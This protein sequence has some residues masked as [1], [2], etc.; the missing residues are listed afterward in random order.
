MFKHLIKSLIILLLIPGLAMAT[1]ESCT[2]V[3]KSDGPNGG[4]KVTMTCTAD[5]TDGSMDVTLDSTQL[6]DDGVT[7]VQDFMDPLWIYT[8]TA[9]P[10]GTAP[11][12]ASDFSM[13]DANGK[14]CVSAT[15]NGLNVIDAT[16]TVEFYTEGPGGVSHY[17]RVDK[18]NDL[19]FSI[20]NNIVNSAII[21]FEW[22]L[23]R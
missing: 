13:V 6:C 18:D 7:Q 3:C 12:D 23:E 21:I 8:I 15:A 22:R 4:R 16:S 19:T 17:Q 10:G 20:T 5:S 2:Y 1:A 11:T 9:R 14:T